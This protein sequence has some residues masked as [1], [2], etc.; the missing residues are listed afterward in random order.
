[1]TKITFGIIAL[2]AQPFLEYNLRALYP[3]AHELIVVEGAVRTAVAIS[4]SDGHSTDDTV[5]MLEAF[6]R[7]EDRDKKL[8]IVYAKDEGYVD[9]FWPEKDEMS[10][11]Y[12]K[13]AKGDWLWQVDSDEFYLEDDLRTVVSMLEAHPEIDAVSFP[14]YEF[15]GSFGSTISGVWHIKEHPLF[16]RL[17]KW[18]KDYVYRTHRPPTVEDENG[19]NLR[20]KNWVKAPKVSN[21]EIKLLH[22]S[23]VFPKQAKLKVGY[24]S[25]VRWTDAFRQ[26]QHWF[27]NSYLG[28][29]A[30]MF[31]G[32][33]G[34]PN[35]QWL[36]TYTGD[37]PVQIQQLRQDLDVG[38]LEERP[39]PIDDI[40]RL[41]AS[42]LYGIQKLLARTFLSFFWPAR[43]I[44][45]KIRHMLVSGSSKNQS[46]LSA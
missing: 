20:K 5:Q 32:E 4:S 46:K 40:D 2:N 8:R 9:G 29:K 3:F 25:S 16:H 1:M 34:W 27:E 7:N 43:Q 10:Q 30:P 42:P 15:F 37:H 22:Y 21:R 31:L 35:L 41:L 45:K 36:E 38:R 13:R 28:L 18:R 24:Y 26:N 11:A 12:A 17:F 19:V 39:R 14:Y 33:K 44:W 23:Y 6:Q